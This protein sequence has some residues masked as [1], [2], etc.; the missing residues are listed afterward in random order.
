MVECLKTRR[1]ATPIPRAAS[2]YTPLA[3]HTR[4]MSRAFLNYKAFQG[5]I[6][7]YPVKVSISSLAV[8]FTPHAVGGAAG[9]RW[10]EFTPVKWAN[11]EAVGMVVLAI[12]PVAKSAIAAR[13]CTDLAGKCLP[14]IKPSG[15]GSRPD[16]PNR[17]NNRRR[18]LRISEQIAGRWKSNT[19]RVCAWRSRLPG[20]PGPGH[21][22]KLPGA[23]AS[24][25]GLRNEHGPRPRP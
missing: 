5:N 9:A 6:A 24:R 10:A 14:G 25:Q 18:R 1:D 7:S 13:P 8:F 4:S 2:G 22:A 19:A 11:A 21:T 23:S 15:Q 3:A 16:Q 20:G 17:G 12:W